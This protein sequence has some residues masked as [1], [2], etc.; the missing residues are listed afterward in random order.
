MSAFLGPIHHWLYNKVLW[1]EALLEQIIRTFNISEKEKETFTSELNQ[2]YG[3][4]ETNPLEEIVELTNIH[5]WLQMKIESLEKRMA[6]TI[7]QGLVNKW[8]HLQSLETLFYENGKQAIAHVSTQIN[9]PSDLFKMM[10]DYLLD[11]MPCDRVNTLLE[12]GENIVTWHRNQCV[13]QPLWDAVN[14]DIHLFYHLRHHWFHAFATH[15]G[16][17]EYKA[18]NPTT[19][20][21]IRS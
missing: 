8:T 14:A 21:F 10:N 17:F 12:S 11:G 4:P 2:L 6:S 5:G 18:I 13:H 20:S 15:A 7:N 3:A 16:S 9:A 1:H 19:Y